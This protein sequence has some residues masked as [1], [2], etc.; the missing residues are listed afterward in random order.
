MRGCLYTEFD[1]TPPPSK[2]GEVSGTLPYALGI[3]G[4]LEG[5][6]PSVVAQSINTSHVWHW[7]I[8]NQGYKLIHDHMWPTNNA[9]G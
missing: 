6:L 4:F 5:E 8:H 1:S 9:P 7:H 3:A 2:E